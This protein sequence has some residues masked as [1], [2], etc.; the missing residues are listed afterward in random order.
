M[1][2]NYHY[3]VEVEV[4]PAPVKVDVSSEETEVFRLGQVFEKAPV[5]E[6]VEVLQSPWAGSQGWREVVP[7]Q[8][9]EQ[10]IAT[11]SGVDVRLRLEIDADD[12]RVVRQA[13]CT[14]EESQQEEARARLRTAVEQAA[15]VVSE[16]I[17]QVLARAQLLV[18]GRRARTVGE[19]VHASPEE[20][21]AENRRVRQK[22]YVNI[23][24]ETR[25]EVL[26]SY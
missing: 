17:H 22:F 14:V 12:V 4:E 19:V 5:G 23:S 21:D 20:W 2:D 11:S 24:Q 1:S 25:A 13:R 3:E 16:Q 9:F 18:V 26:A 10:S 15:P 6:V 8:C 7:G